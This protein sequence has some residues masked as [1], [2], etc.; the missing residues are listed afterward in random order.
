MNIKSVFLVLTVAGLCSFAPESGSGDCYTTFRKPTGLK[1][2]PPEKLAAEARPAPPGAMV[3]AAAP[4]E[5]VEDGIRISYETSEKAP[6]ATVEVVY[7]ADHM[8]ARDTARMLESMTSLNGGF[9]VEDAGIIHLQYN[10]YHLYGVTRNGKNGP[11][12][13]GRFLMF[14][15]LSTSVRISFADVQMGSMIGELKRTAGTREQRQ[16]FLEEYTAHL[17]K[18]RKK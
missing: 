17:K 3:A 7:S 10:G 16:L 13:M 15:E 1:M 9:P 8:Y 5:L 2:L 4:D 6:F 18:C 14:P 12:T 11:D